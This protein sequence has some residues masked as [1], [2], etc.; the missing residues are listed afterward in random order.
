[1]IYRMLLIIAASVLFG[2]AAGSLTIRS[3]SAWGSGGVAG[4]AAGALLS[5]M[6][7]WCFRR[8]RLAKALLWWL[9]PTSIV[10]AILAPLA[11]PWLTLTLVA[12]FAFVSCAVIFVQME[13]FDAARPNHCDRCGYDMSGLE[14]DACPE[15][16]TTRFSRAAGNPSAEI[17]AAAPGNRS[18]DSSGS[19]D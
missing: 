7:A 18:T 6:S 15:C 14:D 8:K 19:A 17:A 5:L 4:A 13:D 10:V 12:L 11:A 3:G 16:G 2:Y 9:G 1:M